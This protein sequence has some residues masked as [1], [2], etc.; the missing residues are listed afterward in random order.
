M[1][2]IAFCSQCFW[3]DNDKLIDKLS[4][5]G[6]LAWEALENSFLRM[7]LKEPRE[8]N[9]EAIFETVLSSNENVYRTHPTSNLSAISVGSFLGLYQ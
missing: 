3:I 1:Y 2:R 7:R 5:S 9:T 8:G 6:N 4:R